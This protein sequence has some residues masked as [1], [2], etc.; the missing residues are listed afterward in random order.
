MAFWK[1]IQRNIFRY[2]EN[3]R[4]KKE[5]DETLN[6][7]IE[8]MNLWFR[9]RNINEILSYLQNI[10]K[11]NLKSKKVIE[12]NKL[13]LVVNGFINYS[14]RKINTKEIKNLLE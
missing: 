9:G 10:N 4:V 2:L 5:N 8:I 14:L 13:E 1:Y 11:Y 12:S 6:K 7:I 3:N